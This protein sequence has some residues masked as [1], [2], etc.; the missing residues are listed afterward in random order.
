MRDQFTFQIPWS[1]KFKLYRIRDGR[2]DSLRA[3]WDMKN[4]GAELIERVA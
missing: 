2:R 1:G 3:I 4:T